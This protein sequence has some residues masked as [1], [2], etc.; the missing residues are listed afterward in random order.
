MYVTVCKYC[1][2]KAIKK[3]LVLTYIM[4]GY[5]GFPS[6]PSVKA[7]RKSLPQIAVQAQ[8]YLFHANT[9]CL[10]WWLATVG[11]KFHLPSFTYMVFKHFPKL[12]H[13]RIASSV[14]KLQEIKIKKINPVRFVPG[15]HVLTTQPNAHTYI[16]ELCF[17]STSSCKRVLFKKKKKKSDVLCLLKIFRK[18]DCCWCIK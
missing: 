1:L 16:H 9:C 11:E 4:A 14:R 17:G 18:C 8:L 7:T 2:G 13:A 10:Y 12:A 6:T 3:A 15:S 5:S